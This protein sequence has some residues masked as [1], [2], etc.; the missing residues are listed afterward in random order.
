MDGYGLRWPLLAVFW[1]YA[2]GQNLDF[3]AMKRVKETTSKIGPRLIYVTF[4]SVLFA[5]A[6]VDH[7]RS[8]VLS[9]FGAPTELGNACAPCGAPCF[10]VKPAAD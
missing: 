8:P 2:C 3:N 9:N 6:I 7:L 4:L 5:M 10:D 1:V